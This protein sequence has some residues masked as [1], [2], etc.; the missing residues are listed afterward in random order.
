MRVLCSHCGSSYSVSDDAVASGPVACRICGQGVAI[1]SPS[2]KPAPPR[3]PVAQGRAPPPQG[4]GSAARKVA[5]LR[6]VPPPDPEPT[7]TPEPIPT[8]KGSAWN[9]RA[10]GPALASGTAPL[11]APPGDGYIDLTIDD[12]PTPGPR[13]GEPPPP[14]ATSRPP[15]ARAPFPAVPPVPRPAPARPPVPRAER[16]P[17]PAPIPPPARETPSRPAAQP[18][19]PAPSKARPVARNAAA[20]APGPGKWLAIGGAAVLLLAAGAFL[21]L[22][23]RPVPETAAPHAS[24]TARYVISTEAPPLAEVA[25]GVVE[26]QRRAAAYPPAAVPE[27]AVRRAADRPQPRRTEADRPAPAA[28]EAPPAPAAQPAPPPA[29]AAPAAVRVD[30]VQAAAPAPAPQEPALEDAPAYATAGFQ[31]PRPE[32][33]NC[34]QNALRIPADLQNFVSGPVTVRFAVTRDGAVSRFEVMGD[35][36]HPRIADAIQQAV[37][38][39]KFV[40]GADAQGTPT[41]LWLVMPI[42]FVAR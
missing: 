39:C 19:A 37:R 3:V 24:G 17:A 21:L 13:F 9:D 31:R 42:R 27:P 25:P 1:P 18:P 4:G 38:S 6:A 34:V 32:V 33:P 41:S 12:V 26:P 14:P 35:G 20:A 8:S 16:T 40:P 10:A 22:R 28:A 15:A 11:P 5:P 2:A 29:P 36:P 7:P 23:G 30:A